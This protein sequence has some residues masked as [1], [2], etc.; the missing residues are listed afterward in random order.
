MLNTFIKNYYTHLKSII[1]YKQLVL[2]QEYAPEQME[3]VP[4]KANF[5][6]TVGH[7]LI[8]YEDRKF[9]IVPNNEIEDCIMLRLFWDNLFYGADPIS[10][11]QRYPRKGESK[12]NQL[13]S[14]IQ[15]F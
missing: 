13:K 10:N 9:F 5:Y 7:F 15:D 14:Y 4:Y 3:H 11:N 6:V 2:K 12:M 8:F 1:F